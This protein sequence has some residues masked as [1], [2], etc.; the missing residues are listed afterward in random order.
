MRKLIKLKTQIQNNLKLLNL[1][2]SNK[3]HENTITIL[4]DIKMDLD[5]LEIKDNELISFYE[6]Y[7]I[8]KEKNQFKDLEEKNNILE[9]FITDV[10]I[11]LK[12]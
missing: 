9:N 10:L 11:A 12:G 6:E 5:K 4:E 1:N 2:I 3:N 8:K 7:K